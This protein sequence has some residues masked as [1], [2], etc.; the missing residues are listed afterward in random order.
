MPGRDFLKPDLASAQAALD[1]AK[2]GTP[3][4]T[5]A[6]LKP[7][8][9]ELAKAREALNAAKAYAKP[10]DVKLAAAEKAFAALRK[11]LDAATQLA[12]QLRK[13]LPTI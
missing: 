11:E 4:P 7:V 10:A 13:D 8:Q 2:S 6:D 12:A 9:A 1:A 5:A 3:I